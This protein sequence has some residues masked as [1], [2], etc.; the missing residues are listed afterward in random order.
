MESISMKIMSGGEQ[1]AAVSHSSGDGQS[2]VYAAEYREGDRVAISVS[3][4][5]LYA[6][7]LDEALPEAVVYIGG[8]NLIFPIPCGDERL[9]YS[10]KAF[11]GSCHLLWVRPATALECAQRRNLAFNPYD[12]HL[13]KGFFPHATANVETRNEAV[14]AARNALDG[15]FENGSHGV[16]PYSSWGINRDPAAELRLDFGRPVRIDSLRLTLR[17][18]FPHDNWWKNA[19]VRF[20]DDSSVVCSLSKTHLPQPIEIEPRVVEWLTLGQLIQ[21][22]EPSPF[23]A[24]TQLEVFGV[25]AGGIGS[26]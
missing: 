24:L 25:E 21:S 16:Y 20:S 22:D 13:A 7:R 14:F 26:K 15:I 12:R 5:G 19:T 4:P 10:P 23:P 18:D 2:I 9:C 11:A 17:A 1:T 6:I 8:G 3:T